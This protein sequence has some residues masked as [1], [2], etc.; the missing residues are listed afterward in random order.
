MQQTLPTVESLEPL[1]ALRNVVVPFGVVAKPI[2]GPA[3]AAFPHGTRVFLMI[4]PN[5]ILS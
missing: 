4:L 3:L 1:R 5:W 2:F